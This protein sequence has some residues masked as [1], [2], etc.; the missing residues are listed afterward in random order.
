MGT[1]VVRCART[2]GW[3]KR[4]R[5][6]RGRAGLLRSAVSDAMHENTIAQLQ[7]LLL[8]RD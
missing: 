8:A 7:G 3:G 2:R 1:F 6:R 5:I 4:S